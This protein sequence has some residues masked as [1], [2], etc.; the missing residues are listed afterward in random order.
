MIHTAKLATIRNTL[1]I[2]NRRA[3]C[4]LT[5]KLFSVSG[6]ARVVRPAVRGFLVTGAWAGSLLVN[7]WYCLSQRRW[8][9]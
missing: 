6:L 5:F 8:E 2:G 3:G 7:V 4:R 9:P 1:T